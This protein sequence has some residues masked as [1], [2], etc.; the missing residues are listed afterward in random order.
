MQRQRHISIAIS[1]ISIL[2]YSALTRALPAPEFGYN[3]DSGNGPEHWGDIK[4]EW[5]ACKIGQIQSPIDLSSKSVQV[6]PML[7]G[8]KYWTY[9]PQHATVLNIGNVIA[10]VWKGDA[11]SID[12]DGTRFPLV[13]AHWHWPSEHTINGRR[14]DL[15]LHMLHV[16]PQPD[17]TNKTAVVGILYK[18]GSPDPL[19][20]KLGEYITDIPEK[21]Q[22]KSV[23]VID[24]SE[25]IKGSK[26]Y[27]RY[28]GSL[29]TP[30]CTEGV[31]WT[32]HNKIRTVSKEQVKLLEDTYA[33]RNARP[34]QPQNEREIQLY[35]SKPKNKPQH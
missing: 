33:K 14:Y 23:G 34:L 18:Y 29:T 28:K 2:F 16:S 31:I 6:I 12:I 8:L 7:E 30:P 22:E 35:V 3:K 27:Y 20:S 26:M 21:N 11:G 9:N 32:V 13:Q 1:L 25:F 10:V 4:E 19:L 17:G 24:P 5:A 15:E